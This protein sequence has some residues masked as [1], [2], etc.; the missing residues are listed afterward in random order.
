[1]RQA[2]EARVFFSMDYFKHCVTKTLNNVW[3]SAPYNVTSDML[4]V[5][6]KR[7]SEFYFV[8]L[9]ENWEQSIL[10]F[11]RMRNSAVIDAELAHAR[12]TKYEGFPPDFHKAVEASDWF[13][14]WRDPFDT[15]LYELGLERHNAMLARHGLAPYLGYNFTAIYGVDDRVPWPHPGR[16]GD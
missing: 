11:N 12:K 2:H 10:L 7:L 16:K 13:Q 5:A 6:L 14:A 8:G 3:C 4:H 15:A 1:M 9:L